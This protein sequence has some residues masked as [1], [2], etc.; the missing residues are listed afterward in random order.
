MPRKTA[1]EV[2]AISRTRRTRSYSRMTFCSQSSP[3][4][5]ASGARCLVGTAWWRVVTGCIPL[6]RNR[7]SKMVVVKNSAATKKNLEARRSR[8]Y[9]SS[10]RLGTRAMRGAW[11]HLLSH[12]EYSQRESIR[13]TRVDQEI[14]P[15]CFLSL[16]KSS[17]GVASE[18]SH[19]QRPH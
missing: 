18:S 6:G 8:R 7:G 1:S 5:L 15:G 11:D 9:F 19:F 4:D 17:L 10:S 13:A 12:D 2:G 16:Q 14:L 3:L